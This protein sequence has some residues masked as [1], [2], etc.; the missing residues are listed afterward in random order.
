MIDV[1]PSLK[2]TFTYIKDNIPEEVFRKL[3]DKVGST[4]PEIG[5]SSEDVSKLSSNLGNESDNICQKAVDAIYLVYSKVSYNTTK[6]SVARSFLTPLIGE[7]H[8]D[9]LS[10][11]WGE[12]AVDIVS[13]LKKSK[14]E[15]KLVWDSSV[16]ISRDDCAKLRETE[17]V[18]QVEVEGNAQN[19]TFDFEGLKKF[20]LELER[21]QSAIDELA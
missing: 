2:K 3:C 7:V 12:H 13:R 10:V 11:C 9:S 1:T 19:V 18:L 17:A 21:I 8:A 6:P 5:V 16:S 4:F 14:T 15:T 20:Y